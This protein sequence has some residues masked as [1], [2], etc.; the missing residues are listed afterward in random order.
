MHNLLISMW[1]IESML[2]CVRYCLTFLT[3]ELLSATS[4]CPSSRPPPSP[5]NWDIRSGCCWLDSTKSPRR[6]PTRESKR[7]TTFSHSFDFAASLPFWPTSLS[8]CA[9]LRSSWIP[10]RS[11]HPSQRSGFHPTHGF[12]FEP[13][14]I[15][16]VSINRKPEQINI[17]TQTHRNRLSFSTWPPEGQETKRPK[18]KS[19]K[20]SAATWF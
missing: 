10:Q 12:M 6:S 13:S 2:L 15:Q 1:S 5:V 4:S 16:G 20:S 17:H 19:F 14:R 18:K 7:L 11:R 9:P 8:I 3:G